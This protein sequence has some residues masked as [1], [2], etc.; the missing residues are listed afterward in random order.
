MVG[1]DRSDLPL[2]DHVV[3]MITLCNIFASDPRYDD[4]LLCISRVATMIR[5]QLSKHRGRGRGDDH[6]CEHRRWD[7]L[8]QRT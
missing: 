5:V 4:L 7:W 6:R 8:S 2:V 1:H 3:E